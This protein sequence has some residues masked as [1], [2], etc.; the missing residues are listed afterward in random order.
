M[1]SRDWSVAWNCWERGRASIDNLLLAQ[2]DLWAHIHIGLDLFVKSS[3]LKGV[4]DLLL[5]W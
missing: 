3:L 5:D 1:Y 2:R 4:G